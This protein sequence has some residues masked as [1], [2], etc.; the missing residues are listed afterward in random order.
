MEFFGLFQTSRSLLPA[1]SAPT[2]S[3]NPTEYFPAVPSP[4]LFF[5]EELLSRFPS[6]TRPSST[7]IWFIPIY[8]IKNQM[9]SEREDIFNQRDHVVVW[10]PS[11]PGKQTVRYHN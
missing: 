1:V 9:E 10:V 2:P 6:A 5:L 3:H 11:W 8:R 7:T 4:F